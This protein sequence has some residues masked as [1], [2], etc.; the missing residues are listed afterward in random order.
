MTSIN[1]EMLKILINKLE[2]ESVDIYSILLEEGYSN[3][4]I[5]KLLR[6]CEI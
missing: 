2:E 3:K 5:D 4:E 1:I 6:D